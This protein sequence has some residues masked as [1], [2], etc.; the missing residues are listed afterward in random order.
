[1]DTETVVRTIRDLKDLGVFWIGLTGGEPLLNKD[2]VEIVE[3]IGD[4]CSSKIFTTGCGLTEGLARDLQSAGLDYVTVSLD[5]WKEEVHDGIRKYRGAYKIA[6]RAIDTLKRIGCVHVGVSAVL[7]KQMI[8][9]REVEEFLEFLRRMEVHEAWL[10]ET[11]PSVQSSW[12]VGFQISEEDR[13]YLVELQDRLNRAG[14][15]TVNYLGH[16]E[17]ARHFGCTA[18][19]KMIYVDPF[20]EVSPCVFIPL[21]FGNVQRKP[22]RDIVNRMQTLFP[23][24]NRCFINA[25]YPVIRKHFNGRAP[26][27]EQESEKVLDEV[28]FGPLAKF[29]DLQYR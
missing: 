3:A 27:D 25:N 26:I 24:E 12:E 21:T 2:L 10:S 19:H 7:S 4:D 8:E 22:I 28:E 11:K 23:S 1:M 9:N 6:L 5:H 16:F 14:G 15:M 17:D 18:G 29:F 20:G 13:I